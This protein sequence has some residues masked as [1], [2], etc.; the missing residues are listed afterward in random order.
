[1]FLLKSEHEKAESLFLSLSLSLSLSTRNKWL[2]LP[3]FVE[4]RK[5]N[6][7]IVHTRPSCDRQTARQVKVAI[8]CRATDVR[9]YALASTI[10]RQKFKWSHLRAEL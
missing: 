4:R 2:V 7:L 1:M 10:P 5:P 9:L 8:G 6:F 3:S